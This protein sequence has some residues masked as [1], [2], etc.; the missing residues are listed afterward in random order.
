MHNR[1][2]EGL[3]FAMHYLK[4]PFIFILLNTVMVL[5][6]NAYRA[7]GNIVIQHESPINFGEP[8]SCFEGSVVQMLFLQLI[9]ALLNHSLGPDLEEL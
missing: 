5:S 6:V 2:Y 3:S 7:P 1:Q 8:E 9:N 4:Y